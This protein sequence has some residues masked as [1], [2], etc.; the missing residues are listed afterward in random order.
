MHSCEDTPL[1]W[2]PLLVAM[3]TLLCVAASSTAGAKRAA[4]QKTEIATPASP[5]VPVVAAPLL[6]RSATL[7][8]RELLDLYRQQERS[9]QQAPPPVDAI[10]QRLEIDARVLDKALTARISISVEVLADKRWVAVPLLELGKHTVLDDLPSVNGAALVVVDGQLQLV[11]NHKGRFE[12]VVGVSSSAALDGVRRLASIAFAG[13]T[14]ARCRLGFD[15]SIFKLTSEVRDTHA[16]FVTL[17]THNNR[18]VVQWQQRDEYLAPSDLAVSAPEAEP[19][20][21]T[22]H[23]SIVSTL[24]GEHILRVAYALRFTGRKPIEFELPPGHVS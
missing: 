17:H 13:A 16:D 12:F 15:Q 18:C 2:R 19:V 7:P 14:L 6:P 4:R 21:P 3:L 9:K 22:A 24:E 20:I 11:A 1:P 5:S 10:V 23:A 8:L